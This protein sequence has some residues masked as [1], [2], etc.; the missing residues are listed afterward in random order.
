MT[1]HLACW[2]ILNRFW[3]YFCH[4]L[5]IFHILVPS[6]FSETSQI[7]GFQ[8]FSL[9]CTREVDW[10][11]TCWCI[12]NTF[13]TDYNLVTVSL[14][15]FYKS[16]AH[17]EPLCTIAT[18]SVNG[19]CPHLIDNRSRHKRRNLWAGRCVS[20]WWPWCPSRSS[21]LIYM[22]MHSLY[23]F[24]YRMQYMYIYI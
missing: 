13:G 7:W 17:R 5:L 8:G 14:N 11:L 6:W 4:G 18:M 12:W 19:P 15:E 20:F 16:P 21:V 9:E 3:L 22:Y 23:E 2:C 10:N 1:W 24:C